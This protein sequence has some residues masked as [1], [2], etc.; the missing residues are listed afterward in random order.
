VCEQDNNDLR[1]IVSLAGQLL[2]RGT[3]LESTQGGERLSRGAVSEALEQHIKD[4]IP[5]DQPQ[6]SLLVKTV[7]AES[8]A[9]AEDAINK[10][11]GGVPPSSLTDVEVASL[12]AII[13]VTGRPAI[14]Y[15]N[16]RIQSPNEL[17]ENERWKLLIVTSRSKIN[18]ASGSVGRIMRKGSAGLPENIGTGWR[19]GGDLVVTNRH[20][21]QLLSEDEKAAASDLKLDNAKQPFIDFSATDD[22][23]GSK[24]FD[25]TA[26]SYCAAEPFVDVAVLRIAATVDLPPSLDLDWNAQSVGRDI[27]GPNGGTPVF[28]GKDVYVVGHPFRQRRSQAIATVFGTADGLKRWSPGFVLR[29]DT[30]QPTFRHDCSTLG[31]SAQSSGN[32]YGRC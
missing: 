20:V 9:H 22:S 16:G 7:A 17:G 13:E 24:K 2:N 8:L 14:R 1:Q 30:E 5:Q 12:E 4:R 31:G 21:A 27:P 26:I 28:Q 19:V 3:T 23:D 6:A 15:S 29:V 11:A 18:N 32:P 10:T 25:L